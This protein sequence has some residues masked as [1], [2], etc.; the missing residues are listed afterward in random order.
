MKLVKFPQN[1]TVQVFGLGR[2]FPT[3]AEKWLHSRNHH[4]KRRS[5]R[6]FGGPSASQGREKL[7]DVVTPERA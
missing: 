2:R 4:W 1:Q 3:L 7:S 6:D 5:Y